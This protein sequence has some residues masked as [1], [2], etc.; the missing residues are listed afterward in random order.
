MAF[1]IDPQWNSG[2]ATQLLCGYLWRLTPDK[3]YIPIKKTALELTP[4]SQ[5]LIV[6]FSVK[7]IEKM[8]GTHRSIY[9]IPLWRLF[10]VSRTYGALHMSNTGSMVEELSV[11]L[12][13]SVLSYSVFRSLP[14]YDCLRHSKRCH[15]RCVLHAENNIWYIT[16]RDLTAPIHICLYIDIARIIARSTFRW[17]SLTQ[18][19]STS[20]WYF[21]QQKY[22]T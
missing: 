13:K 7:T 9:A 22:T 15:G 21:Y 1:A 5:A 3:H 18:A 12:Y 4:L 20:A 8:G 16:S 10:K 19:R 14:A 17:K 11:L 6:A 2:P